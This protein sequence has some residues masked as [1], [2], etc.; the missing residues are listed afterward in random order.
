MP[1]KY[2]WNKC[3]SVRG[4][5]V[6]L[7]MPTKYGE[8]FLTLF[9]KTT[10]FQL[11]LNFEQTSTLHTIFKRSWYNGSYTMMAKPIRYNDS[12]FNKTS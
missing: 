11:I 5:I 4:I 8:Y 2:E 12:V 1:T 10:D 7:K 3:V 6:L 9:G